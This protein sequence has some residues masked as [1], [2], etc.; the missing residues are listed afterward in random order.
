MK[1]N[2]RQFYVYALQDENGKAFYI[3]KGCG[4]RVKRH[5]CPSQKNNNTHK[6]RKIQKLLRNGVNR[7]DIIHKIAVGME[8]DKALKLEKQIIDTIGLDNLTNVDEGGG[9]APRQIGV[10]NPLAKLSSKEAAWIKYLIHNSEFGG[11]NLCYHYQEYFE[12][13]INPNNFGSIRRETAWGHIE[14]EKPPFWD[15]EFENSRKAKIEKRYKA[16]CEWQDPGNNKTAAEVA[17]FYG[18]NRGLIYGAKHKNTFGLWD[19]FLG[20]HPEYL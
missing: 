14:P 2:P 3:G 7:T 8:E 10:N 6:W 17:N 16:L 12:S 4:Q 9:Y 5:F 1:T 13:D 11:K 15:E 20:E 18:I 19:R